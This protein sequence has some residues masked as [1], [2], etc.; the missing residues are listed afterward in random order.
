MTRTIFILISIVA[1]VSFL[2]VDQIPAQNRSEQ[3]IVFHVT[4]IHKEEA[5]EQCKNL[6]CLAVRWVIEGY[7]DDVSPTHRIGYVLRCFRIVSNT[8]SPHLL[9]TCPELHAGNNYP[10]TWSASGISFGNAPDWPTAYEIVSEKELDR[11]AK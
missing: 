2:C 4:A 6:D 10:A 3:K 5:P 11:P 1:A 8:P 9:T 7:S